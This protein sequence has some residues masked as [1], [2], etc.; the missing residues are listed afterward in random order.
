M[1]MARMLSSFNAAE[2]EKMGDFSAIPADDYVAKIVNSEMKETKNKDGHYLQLN[3]QVIDGEFNGRM[4]FER[5]NIQNKNSQTVEIA[6]KTLA[7][8][9]ELCNVDLLDDSEQL[10]GVPM[11]IR[12]TVKEATAQYSEQNEIKGYE[13]YDGQ[14][15]AASTGASNVGTANPPSAATAGAGKKTP[16]WKNK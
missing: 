13:S 2:N 9:C 8:I 3:F 11:V 7:T 6:Q 12:V 5:L 10:H 15:I 4:I 14:P 16:P 1:K